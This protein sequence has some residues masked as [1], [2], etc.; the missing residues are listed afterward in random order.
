MEKN[1]SIKSVVEQQNLN[2][3]LLE[4]VK[5]K[6]IKQAEQALLEGASS[7]EHN[8]LSIAIRQGDAEMVE[9]LI[10]NGAT[11][12]KDALFDVIVP[13]YQAKNKN[14]SPP[15]NDLALIKI[16][17][18]LLANGADANARRSGWAAGAL[19]LHFAAL[20][21]RPELAKLLL[22]EG[23]DIYLKNNGASVS[24]FIQ[25]SNQLNINLPQ[26]QHKALQDY[27]ITKKEIRA[28]KRKEPSPIIPTTPPQKSNYNFFKYVNQKASKTIT[29]TLTPFAVLFIAGILFYTEEEFFNNNKKVAGSILGFFG[30]MLLIS[31]ITK[32]LSQVHERV[33]ANLRSS[34]KAIDVL[35]DSI[36]T[37]VKDI[38]DS[39]QSLTKTTENAI[40]LLKDET[41]NTLVELRGSSKSVAQAIQK[42]I[43][44]GRF[45]PTATAHVVANIDIEVMPI[46]NKCNIM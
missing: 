17:K 45:T 32:A 31:N 22:I 13:I 41:A 40:V 38:K 27:D 44:E 46:R 14:E 28:Y 33:I 43:N 10:N 18:L 37:S 20:I 6:N 34:Q 42:G 25:L 21:E 12:Y 24:N 1:T 23:A 35:S 29:H 8:V 3:A 39:L 9:L 15:Y 7:N 26:I 2:N 4:A 30:S 36:S 19:P 11:V 5:N 16:A